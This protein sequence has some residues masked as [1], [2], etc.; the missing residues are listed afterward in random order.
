MATIVKKPSKIHTA[1][2]PVIL[3]LEAVSQTEREEGV[4]C[5]LTSGARVSVV[6]RE[7]FND[8]ARF[9][10]SGILKYW[11]TDETVAMPQ[12]AHCFLD[13]RLAFAYR[14]DLYVPDSVAVNAVVQLG[15]NPDMLTWGNRFLTNFPILRK[16]EGYPLDVSYLNNGQDAQVCF[17]GGLLNANQ[18]IEDL[19]FSIDI[20]D[21]VTSVGV[22]PS[23]VKLLTRAG[24][25]ILANDGRNIV[26]RNLTHVEEMLEVV[27]SCIPS[28]PLYVR[29]INRLG[30]F[31]Y[32][33]FCLNQVYSRSIKTQTVVSP[34]IDDILNAGYTEYE[35]DK[36]V[37][38]SLSVGAGNLTDVEYN[39]LLGL[40]SSP[41][42]EMWEAEVGRWFRAYVASGSF[43]H[44]TRD[45]R[46]EI[47]IELILPVL[48]TQF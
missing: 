9:D 39:E 17:N 37:G 2:N 27:P 20:P 16:Y 22:V 47:E 15:R 42:V 43:E 14:V 31:D 4:E 13:R 48:Q 5:T 21:G 6:R 38:R 19:H 35:L 45:L 28:S 18:Q 8:N 12:S 25:E 23:C 24:D 26:V 36:E 41:C 3:Q 11:F 32:R 10:L 1:F 33:M 29:W 30:G 34:V 40:S 7:F 46:K 44:D